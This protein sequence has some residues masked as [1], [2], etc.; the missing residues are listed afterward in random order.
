[1]KQHV[2]A[3]QAHINKQIAKVIQ[4]SQPNEPV[5]A[6][7]K[8]ALKLFKQAATRVPAYKDF[9]QS[10]DIDYRQINTPEDYQKIPVVT[11]ENY[12]KKYPIRELVW[13]G[14]V[15]AARIISMS[16]GSSGQPF[17]WPRG[18]ESTED[19]YKILDDLYAKV[20]QTR[21]KS[22]LCINAYAMGTWIAGTYMLSAL[23]K[24]ADNGHK[25]VTVTPGINKEEIIQ[26]IQRLGDQFDQ[27]LIMGYAPF[28][29][30]T[31]ETAVDQGIDLSTCDLKF[32]FSS[33]FITETWRSYVLEQ[34]KKGKDSES[35]LCLYGAADAGIIGMET[36]LIIHLRKIIATKPALQEALF[37]GSRVLP[38][39]VYYQPELRFIEEVD[40]KFIFTMNSTIPLIRYDLLD[41]G[42]LLTYAQFTDA[43]KAAG[44]KIPSNLHTYESFPILAL[45]GRSDVAAM[46]YGVNIYPENIRVA[47][48][49]AEIQQYVTGKFVVRT[50]FDSSQ[51]QSLW[52][53]IELRKNVIIS[54]AIEKIMLT[55]IT[56]SL[57]THNSE[58]R[59]LEEVISKKAT[60]HL[61]F[62][63]HGAPEFEIGKKH[64][65]VS[66][67]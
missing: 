55:G 44:V 56:D 21:K 23:Y 54:S 9:L 57:K 67:P 30:D 6:G 38:T 46:F 1:M 5:P 51:H 62:I 28:I 37:P 63:A 35:S 64:R 50:E 59:K 29:K 20:Y 12:F 24:L 34:V 47:L 8:T 32:M 48:E 15:E 66:K 43:I 52:I 42:R 2:K 65:W 10:H 41:E 31:I 4:L 26:I 53:D 13:D 14:D 7:F 18:N 17:L 16:S 3:A 27:I 22:T 45:Y 40:Q 11:K 19:A 60:P 33:E 36:P 58:Y 39:I 25:I 61:R 49:Q